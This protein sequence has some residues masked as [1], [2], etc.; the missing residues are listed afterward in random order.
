MYQSRWTSP[1]S[2]SILCGRTARCGWYH[3]TTRRHVSRRVWS[4]RT[5]RGQI[6]CLWRHTS[7]DH[8]IADNN[9]LI[10]A[11]A[12]TIRDYTEQQIVSTT[13]TCWSQIF[14]HPFTACM[15]TKS[16]FGDRGRMSKQLA[17]GRCAAVTD[18]KSN[19]RPL[20]NTN[21]QKDNVYGAVV[22]TKTLWDI[23]PIQLRNVEQCRHSNQANQC[24]LWVRV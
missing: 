4:P 18:R 12:L 5:I 22:M 13:L 24:G 8:V 19:M 23:H 17:Q 6:T 7:T 20:Y 10:I 21:T 2:T 11:V 15:A 1:G 9:S 3:A 14:I 16:L